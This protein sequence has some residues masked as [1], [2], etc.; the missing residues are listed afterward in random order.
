LGLNEK[1]NQVFKFLKSAIRRAICCLVLK[2][3]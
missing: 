1:Q 2:I 3:P